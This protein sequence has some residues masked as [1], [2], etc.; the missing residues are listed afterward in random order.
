LMFVLLD[1]IPQLG[2]N[3]CFD[4]FAAEFGDFLLKN[5]RNKK[6]G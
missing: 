3:K 1:S 2:T 5:P 4:F 6:C